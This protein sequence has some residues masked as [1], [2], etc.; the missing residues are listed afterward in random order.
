MNPFAAPEKL[1]KLTVEITTTCNLKCAGCPRTTGIEKGTWSDFNM[2]IQLFRQIL[3]NLPEVSFVTLHGIGEPTL[4]P[5]FNE[6]VAAAKQSGKFGRIK[7]TTN[8]LARSSEYYI[9]SVSSGLDEFWISVD[10]FDQEIADKMRYGTKVEKLKRKISEL[11]AMKLPVHISMVVSSVNY[12]DVPQTLKILHSLGAPPVHMQEF[13]DFGNAYGLMTVEQRK[14]FISLI[15]KSVSAIRGMHIYPPNYA[16]P[17]GD[18]CTAPWFRPGITAQGY[19]TPCCTTFDPSQ[20][21]YANIAEKSFIEIWKHPGVH[22]WIKK[23]LANETDICHGC[24]LNPRKFGVNNVLGVSGKKGDEKH[25][26][27]TIG[28]VMRRPKDVL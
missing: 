17:Q 15:Q 6:I 8:A 20:F 1:A 14:E 13:Q 3:D 7:M 25:I 23:F 18:I 16:S 26:V 24:G 4:H 9:Q 21:D 28:E 22:A 19:F 10:T 12:L 2:P 5:E 11:I 27:G